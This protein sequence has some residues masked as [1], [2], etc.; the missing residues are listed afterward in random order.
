MKEE[1]LFG[2]GQIFKFEV[3]D[4]VGGIVINVKFQLLWGFC[5]L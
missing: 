4:E 1:F 3:N 5:V 2:P